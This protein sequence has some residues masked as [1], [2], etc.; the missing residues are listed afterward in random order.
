MIIISIQIFRIFAI[1]MV[2]EQ[3]RVLSDSVHVQVSLNLGFLVMNI[4]K[5]T[6]VKFFLI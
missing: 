4:H 3:K 1:N 6:P 2:C 5:H